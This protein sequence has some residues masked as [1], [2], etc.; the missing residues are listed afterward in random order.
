MAV[1]KAAPDGPTAIANLHFHVHRWLRGVNLYAKHNGGASERSV[2]GNLLVWGTLIELVGNQVPSAS[3]REI[4]PRQ[5]RD[6]DAVRGPLM[7]SANI[8][9]RR[10]SAIGNELPKGLGIH[11]YR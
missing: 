1:V 4:K 8:S 2:E 9:T 7:R 5:P 11:F 6:F 3:I 10:L